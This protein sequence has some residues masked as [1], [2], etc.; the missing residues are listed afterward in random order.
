SPDGRLLLSAGNGGLVRLHTLP[1]CF[2]QQRSQPPDAKKAKMPPLVVTSARSRDG[3]LLLKVN[4]DNSASLIDAQSGQAIGPPLTHGSAVIY[5][6]FSPDE[7]KAVT[8]SE[9]QS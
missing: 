2:T 4:D 7:T 3:R 6:A 1:Q 9:D 8:T 5:V